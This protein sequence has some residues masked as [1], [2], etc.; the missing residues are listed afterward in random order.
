MTPDHFE[1]IVDGSRAPLSAAY[2]HNPL[3]PKTVTVF[4]DASPSG[5]NRAAHAVALA[6]RWD[7]HLV[8]LDVVF[9]GVTLPPW[10]SFPV[11]EVSVR[12]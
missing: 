10:T 7:A 1:T 8:A 9:D 6:Q 2:A 11:G 4:L 3:N 5:R 12:L